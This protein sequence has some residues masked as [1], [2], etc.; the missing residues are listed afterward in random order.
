MTERK[1]GNCC[2]FLIDTASLPKDKKDC[3]SGF[4]A[5]LH[6]YTAKNEVALEI[7]CKHHLFREERK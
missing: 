6:K 5:M 4:C 1:C 2:Y 3:N 7:K